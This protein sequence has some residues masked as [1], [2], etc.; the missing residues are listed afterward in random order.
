MILLF[1]VV[2]LVFLAVRLVAL[3]VAAVAAVCDYLAKEDVPV[4]AGRAP[5]AD[6]ADG[7]EPRTAPVPQDAPPHAP[8]SVTGPQDARG[9]P[10]DAPLDQP[11]GEPAEPARASTE[12]DD[13]A[14]APPTLRQV[15]ALLVAAV[16]AARSHRASLTTTEAADG[17]RMLTLVVDPAPETG[18]PVDPEVPEEPAD[19]LTLLLAALPRPASGPAY[20]GGRDDDA[21]LRG[22]DDGVDWV[23][24]G[25]P[26]RAP[27]WSSAA[28]M[29]GWNDSLRAANKI[30][31]AA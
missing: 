12:P 5:S 18:T 23:R 31:C 17:R 28:Y 25:N 27:S 4:A 11:L 15:L 22:W 24:E 14:S 6:R 19:P 16:V 13:T 20:L 30:R 29:T 9:Y 7:A 8:S 26:E 10:Q 2:A 1:A 21:Y 3:C